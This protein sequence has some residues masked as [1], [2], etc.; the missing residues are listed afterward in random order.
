MPRQIG[1]KPNTLI[2]SNELTASC[3]YRNKWCI[4]VN[5]YDMLYEMYVEWGLNPNT[6]SPFFFKF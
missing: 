4:N 2:C 6:P 1:S 3:V 5:I